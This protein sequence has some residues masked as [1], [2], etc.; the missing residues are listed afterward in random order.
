MEHLCAK[1]SECRWR[2]IT[3]EEVEVKKGGFT[4][5]RLSPA[6]PPPLGLSLPRVTSSC[7][8]VTAGGEATVFRK[9]NR[10]TY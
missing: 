5:G 7:S 4:V 8:A 3:E 9:C 1:M 6:L 10:H 2:K